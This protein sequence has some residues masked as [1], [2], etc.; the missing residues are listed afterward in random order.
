M[1][2]KLFK[3]K[4][5]KTNKHNFT[6]AKNLFNLKKV[7]VGKMS[8]G[9]LEVFGWQDEREGLI[10]GNFVSIAEGVKF[11]MGGNHNIKAFSTYPFRVKMLGEKSEAW[12]KGK[13]VINDDV[14]IGMDSMILSGVTIGKG[15]IIAARSVVT[16]DIPPYAI[17]GGNPAKFIKYRFSQNLIDKMLNI[18]LS[19]INYNFS[20]ENI[21]YLYKPLDEEILNKLMEKL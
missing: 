1:K 13:I 7:T 17:V 11:L 15:A 6:F 2:M 16:K 20:K 8:Y 14:W 18:D 4:W 12:S 5:R 21:N 19:K 3:L 9:P 10:I